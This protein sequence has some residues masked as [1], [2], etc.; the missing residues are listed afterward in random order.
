MFDQTPEWYDRF[1]GKLQLLDNVSWP[2]ECSNCGVGY[3]SNEDFIAKASGDSVSTGLSEKTDHA[4]TEY[5]GL[6]RYCVCG[7]KLTGMFKDRRDNSAEGQKAR[8]FF[9]DLLVMLLEA[10]MEREHAREELLKLL[11]GKPNEILKIS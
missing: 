1:Y 5:V 10:G 11:Q 6:S 8:A 7:C 9:D 2:R 4:G 3:D